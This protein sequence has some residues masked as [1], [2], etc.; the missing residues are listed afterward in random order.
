MTEA[1]KRA[2]QKY[3]LK[4]KEKLRQRNLEYR[5]STPELCMLRA[6]KQRALKRNL[7]FNI[8]K[9]DIIIPEYCPV[10]GIKLQRQIGKGKILDSSP[11]LDRIDNSLGYIKGNI[12]VISNKA[13]AMKH[14][15]SKQEL[16]TFAKWIMSNETSVHS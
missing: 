7:E 9:E 12:Q 2:N 5:L 3:A 16:L 14:S 10:F 13:N 1:H 6:A 8:E 11:S 4:N 15:A